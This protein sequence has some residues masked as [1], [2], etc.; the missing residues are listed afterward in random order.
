M[1][2]RFNICGIN[3]RVHLLAI[4][5]CVLMCALGDAEELAIACVALT[6]HELG[7]VLAARLMEVDVESLDIAPFGGV[8]RL[9]GFDDIS[10]WRA[11]FVCLSG[12][13]VNLILAAVGGAL[14]WLGV[15]GFDMAEGILRVNLIL[16]IFN[17]LPALPLDGGRAFVRI[18]RK[19]FGARAAV[20]AAS[21]AAYT[22]AGAMVGLCVWAFIESG[23]MNI[24][25]IS[26]AVFLIAATA[27]GRNDALSGDAMSAVN[28]I[29]REKKLPMAARIVA[30][31]HDTP[32]GTAVR[33]MKTDIFTIFYKDDR[34]ISETEIAAEALAATKSTS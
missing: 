7:H 1:T 20:N 17:M 33:F 28:A 32:P 34:L 15:M 27:D 13:F 18:T 2:L 9:S 23:S 22:V 24:T 5:L 16:A 19:R 10:T 25:L 8:A 11:I 3:V 14:G 4:L 29:L 31:D 6:F 21:V 26:T 12:I 30:L